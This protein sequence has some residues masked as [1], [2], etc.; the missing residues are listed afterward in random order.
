MGPSQPHPAPVPPAPRASCATTTLESSLPELLIPK[1]QTNTR[2]DF[3]P[4]AALGV[5]EVTHPGGDPGA[6]RKSISHRSH[7]FEVAF[8]WEL[9]EETFHLPQGCLQGGCPTKPKRASVLWTLRWSF[10]G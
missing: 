8:V 4:D 1:P 6:N 7:R 5:P 9:S 10:T 3:H 2:T